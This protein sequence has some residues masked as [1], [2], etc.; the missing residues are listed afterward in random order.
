MPV[1]DGFEFMR[2]F[3]RAGG[4]DR[5]PVVAI[6]GLASK[7]DREGT[8]AAGFDAHLSKPFDIDALVTTVRGTL[9]E[10]KSAA[11]L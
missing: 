4:R 9:D 10:R 2:A 3:A 1:M 5:P 8:R 6:S 7:R 11:A